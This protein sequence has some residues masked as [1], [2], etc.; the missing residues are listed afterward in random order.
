MMMQ[1]ARLAVAEGRPE[2]ALEALERAAELSE[3]WPVMPAMRGLAAGLEAV[4]RA[5]LGGAAA[6]EAQLRDATADRATSEHAAALARLRLLAGD[7]GGA[8][9]ALAPWLDGAAGAYGPTAVELWLLEAL[10]HEREAEGPQ[11]AA[12]LERALDEAEPQG[13]RR[14]FVELGAPIATL[15]RRQ[16]RQGSGH[17]SLVEALLQELGRP[18]ADTRPRS[19]LVEP[20]SDREAAVLRFL[21]TMMSNGEIAGELFVSIN[22]VKTHL[23]SIY[24]KLDVPDRREAVRRARDLGLLAP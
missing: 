3:G 24:R 7:A 18:G 20:L 5:A 14:P 21:P 12:A 19:L 8:H 22:T 2:P 6:A 13:V 4:S 16:L 17:R 11:A 23:K 9:A 10:A 1:R 15:L